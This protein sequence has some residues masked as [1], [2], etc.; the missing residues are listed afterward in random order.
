MFKY[1]SILRPVDIGTYPKR[2]FKG[3]KNYDTRIEVKGIMA[4]GELYY[5]RELSD[6][7]LSDYELAKLV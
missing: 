1:L 4:W 3:F 7:E 6:K 5:D 2:G